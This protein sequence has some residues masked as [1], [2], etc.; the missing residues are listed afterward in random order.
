M[1]E[2][3]SK[4]HGGSPHAPDTPEVTVPCGNVVANEQ[5]NDGEQRQ[6]QNQ[7]QIRSDISKHVSILLLLLSPLRYSWCELN[8]P[9]GVE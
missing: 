2:K 4:L 9:I 3:R 5:C 8:R 7:T 1:A 6:Q